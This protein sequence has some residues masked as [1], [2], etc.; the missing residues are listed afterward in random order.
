MPSS[1]LNRAYE[2]SLPTYLS[3][4]APLQSHATADVDFASNKA[5]GRGTEGT[6]HSALEPQPSMLLHLPPL[7]QIPLSRSVV[8]STSSGVGA[9]AADRVQSTRMHDHSL[10]TDGASGSSASRSGA[11]A[12]MPRYA[13]T[14]PIKRHGEHARDGRQPGLLS[15]QSEDPAAASMPLK[16]VQTPAAGTASADRE[17]VASATDSY[18]PGSTV[19]VT[20]YTVSTADSACMTS[21]S[22][23]AFRA[24]GI[25]ASGPAAVSSVDDESTSVRAPCMH[26]Q[27]PAATGECRYGSDS[28]AGPQ[29]CGEIRKYEGL[30]DH[31]QV[32][33]A[34]QGGHNRNQEDPLGHWQDTLRLLPPAHVRHVHTSHVHAPT[35]PCASTTMQKLR[36]ESAGKDAAIRRLQR[37]LDSFGEHDLF[38]GRFVML[39]SDH[40]HR[41]GAPANCMHSMHNVTCPLQA[42]RPS[43]VSARNMPAQ[44]TEKSHHD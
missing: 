25:P 27:L 8:V 28:A 30:D 42:V 11:F 40:R 9:Q 10:T 3:L 20:P 24:P 26:I 44:L 6:H 16:L 14:C 43:P 39:G 1:A 15:I 22:E 13:E 34:E 37:Q 33:G 36:A 12:T 18:E 21:S 19:V 31:K 5:I 35:L 41:G 17:W 29:F 4:L 7:V 2:Y 38:L 32:Y 23:H